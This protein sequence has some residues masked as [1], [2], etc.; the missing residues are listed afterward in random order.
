MKLSRLDICTAVFFLQL[1]NVQRSSNTLKCKSV[2]QIVV[3]QAVPGGVFQVSNVCMPLGVLEVHLGLFAILISLLGSAL[4]SSWRSVVTHECVL[5]FQPYPGTAK[6]SSQFVTNCTCVS[7]MG[8]ASGLAALSC[9]KLQVLVWH[10]WVE[11]ACLTLGAL[12]CCFIATGYTCD[13]F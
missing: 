9:S 4:L 1:S 5:A 8:C 13:L 7:F 10:R 11:H 3:Y 12:T 2:A 6:D